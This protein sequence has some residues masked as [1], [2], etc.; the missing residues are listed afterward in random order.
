[1]RAGVHLPLC[2]LLDIEG[3]THWPFAADIARRSS[4]SELDG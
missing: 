4:A 2:G 1:V 3:D